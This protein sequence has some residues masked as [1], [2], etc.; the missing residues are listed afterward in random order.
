MNRVRPLVGVWLIAALASFS[1]SGCVTSAK[2]R[3]AGKDTP[4]AVPMNFTAGSAALGLQLAAVIVYEGPGAWKQKALWDEYV[5]SLT[6]RSAEPLTIDGATLIDMLGAG[7]VPGAD[8]WKLEKLSE[9][10]WKQYVRVGQV[11]LGVGAAAGAVELAVIGAGIAGGGAAILAVVPVVLITDLAVVAVL[12]HRNKDKVEKEFT[13][14]RHA[15]PLTLAPGATA[16]GSFFFPL[17]PGPQ[18]LIVRG[19][20]RSQTVEVVL[21]LKPLAGLHRQPVQ[22]K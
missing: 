22:G 18:R 1:L 15:L 9:A 14:R 19:R 4:P 11:V 16:Q 21:D 20:T 6:N 12:N 7:Q 3:L 2:Y 5:V 10:N 17:A 13:R 8:P